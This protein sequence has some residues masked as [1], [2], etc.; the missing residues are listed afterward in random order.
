VLDPYQREIVKAI[1]VDRSDDDRL[2]MSEYGQADKVIVD[3][4]TLDSEACAPCQYMVD[5]VQKVAPEFEGIVIWREHKIK[6][7]ESLVF[8]TSL[9]VRNVRRSASTA[10][11]VSS[12][13][14][15]ARSACGGD[16]GSIN[17]KFRMK[18]ARRKASL[19]VLG[20]GGPDCQEMA[21]RCERA[22]AE[23][24]A[25]AQSAS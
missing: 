18:I 16:P 12:R 11:S 3:I 21:A 24:G 17:E 7:R 13:E 9:M 8:M 14:S 19:Y 20:D 25:D 6:Y 1:A 23:L 2:D 4:I 22:I 5:A 10:R 15:P